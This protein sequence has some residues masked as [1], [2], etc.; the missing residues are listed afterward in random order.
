M[1][2]WGP[3]RLFG[4]CLL[5]GVPLHLMRDDRRRGVAIFPMYSYHPLNFVFL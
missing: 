2:I 1:G 3:L 5:T 4:V